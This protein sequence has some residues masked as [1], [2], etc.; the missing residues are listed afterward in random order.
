[1]I[2]V[3]GISQ[4]V[5]LPALAVP[6][7]LQLAEVVLPRLVLQEAGD[8]G[9][10]EVVLGQAV[11]LQEPRAVLELAEEGV[12]LAIA[13]DAGV[14]VVPGVLALAAQPGVALGQVCEVPAQLAAAGG[15]A[16]GRGA[17]PLVLHQEAVPP[18]DPRIVRPDAGDLI[19]LYVRRRGEGGGGGVGQH[20]GK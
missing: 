6:E 10:L 7:E 14:G 3:F 13:A 20:Q 15:A 17:L 1:M 11:H 9:Q 12:L 8:V 5:A 19:A 16:G 2:G 4:V 18:R